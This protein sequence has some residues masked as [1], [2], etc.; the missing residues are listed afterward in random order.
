VANKVHT[1]RFPRLPPTQQRQAADEAKPPT[2]GL[3]NGLK[4]NLGSDDFNHG[5]A[6][7]IN[8]RCCSMRPNVG[9]GACGGT[10]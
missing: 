3:A 5:R 10:W 2:V 1:D 9:L 8:Q 7:F 6:A 4:L